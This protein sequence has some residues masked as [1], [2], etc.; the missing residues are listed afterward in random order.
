M[1][2][3]MPQIRVNWLKIAEENWDPLSV[4]RVAGIPK[5]WT[6]PNEKASATVCAVMLTIGTAT[7]HLVNLSTAVRR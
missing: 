2:I 3:R 1:M 6:Q 7:G 5:C 4:V